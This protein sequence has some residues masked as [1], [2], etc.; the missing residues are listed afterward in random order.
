MTFQ[1]I[2][3]NCSLALSHT[4]PPPQQ[5]LSPSPTL[6]LLHGDCSPPLLPPPHLSSSVATVSFSLTIGTTPRLSS[7]RKVLLAFRYCDLVAMLD[8]VMST[9]EQVTSYAD[10]S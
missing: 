8:A 4:P 5:L 7:W 10:N 6:H 2:R 1:F 9:W 3:G